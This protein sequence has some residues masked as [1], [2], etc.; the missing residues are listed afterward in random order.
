MK[1]LVKS[2]GRIQGQMGLPDSKTTSTRHV[3][4]Q[5]LLSKGVHDMNICCRS[6][7]KVNPCQMPLGSTLDNLHPSSWLSVYHTRSRW[8]W[9]NPSQK[10]KRSKHYWLLQ[11]WWVEAAGQE[12]HQ[13]RLTMEM[14]EPMLVTE[15]HP[16]GMKAYSGH[17]MWQ[18]NLSWHSNPHFRVVLWK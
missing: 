2:R 16:R 9:D 4:Y 18:N 17:C 5:C 14:E 8:N 15:H 7:W 6:E 1:W 12:D 10:E 13:G 11:L 3:A